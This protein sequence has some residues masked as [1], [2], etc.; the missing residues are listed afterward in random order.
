MFYIRSLTLVI[1][2]A[3]KDGTSSIFHQKYIEIKKIKRLNT[4]Q[5]CIFFKHLSSQQYLKIKLKC[6][7]DL[8]NSHDFL[9][10]RFP[11]CRLFRQQS[12]CQHFYVIK[13]PLISAD[14]K[15]TN[16]MWINFYLLVS[17]YHLPQSIACHSFH[18]FIRQNMTTSDVSETS[19]SHI[20][21]GKPSSRREDLKAKKK[22]KIR[23]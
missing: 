10:Y 19:V 22:K 20:E 21:K 9:V 23:I 15:V 17:V 2:A 3:F 6:F 14:P 7:F 12:K 8:I 16:Q 4:P 11:I 18:I 1:D 5:R 13:I